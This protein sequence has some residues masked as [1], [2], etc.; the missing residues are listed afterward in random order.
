MSS[1]GSQMSSRPPRKTERFESH[2]LQGTVASE[3]HQVGPR[4]FLP[5][6]LFDRP[7]QYGALSRFA[8]SGQLLIGANRWLPVPAPAATVTDAVRACAVP[9]HPDEE[10]PIVTVV[11]WPP[12]LRRGHQVKDVF[13][14]GI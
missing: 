8:L 4:D 9:G 6:F 13:F 10:R 7:K 1:S 2:R 12:V 3:D 14:Q 5:I 11:G